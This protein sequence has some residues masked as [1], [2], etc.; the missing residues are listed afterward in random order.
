MW[1][2]TLEPTLSGG[3]STDLTS[4]GFAPGK[5]MYTWPGG[6]RLEGISIT[7][8]ASQKGTPASPVASTGLKMVDKIIDSS[9]S[10]C[11]VS[12][13]QIVWDVGVRYPLLTG[14]DEDAVTESYKKWLAVV[15]DAEFLTAI[16]NGT[17]PQ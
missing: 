17:F 13:N 15:S 4:S 9:E 10:C 11:S 16:L 1:T 6:S 12:A 7:L 14:V 3:T 5:A 8:T 2:V